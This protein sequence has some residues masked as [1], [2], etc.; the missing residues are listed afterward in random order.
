M[1]CVSE[2]ELICARHFSFHLYTHV[3]VEEK[4][5]PGSLHL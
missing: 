1:D 4:K 3:A 5:M 2:N